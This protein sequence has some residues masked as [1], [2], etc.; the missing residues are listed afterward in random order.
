MILKFMILFWINIFDEFITFVE[1]IDFIYLYFKNNSWCNLKDMKI[2]IL[3]NK[4]IVNHLKLLMVSNN[5]H[6]HGKK[7]WYSFILLQISK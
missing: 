2:F 3:I 1:T 5:L 4:H 6:E 7:N